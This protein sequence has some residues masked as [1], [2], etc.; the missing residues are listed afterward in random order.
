ME[1]IGAYFDLTTMLSVNMLTSALSLLLFVVMARSQRSG[2]VRNS[3]H[4][5]AE[6]YLLL[7]LGFGILQIPA[8]DFPLPHLV[9]IANLVID[10]GVALG[11]VAAN[12]L[13]D[14]PARS[15]WPL[16]LPVALA[17]AQVWHILFAPLAYDGLLMLLGC[18]SRMSMA[19]AVG[20]VLWR[21]AS[22]VQRPPARLAAVFHGIWAALL[23]LRI[24]V[25]LAG[26]GDQTALEVSSSVG[27]TG[28]FMLTWMI[29]ICLLWILARHLD[30]Q[31]VQQASRDPLTNLL[32]RRA[33]WEAG[34]GRGS[35]PMELIMLDIDHFKSINDRWGHC[36]GDEVL[37]LVARTIA[38]AVR[39]GDM[40]ARV[41][42]EE[43][44]VL[45][46]AGTDTRTNNIAERIRV[47]VAEARLVREDGSILQCTVSIGHARASGGD[48]R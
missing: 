13:L 26:G 37:T 6:S 21:H 46:A 36:V 32:N 15:N 25:L 8:E 3:L 28:R 43:F 34:Q 45:P 11:L 35:R 23:A 40:V 38:A 16:A 20:W 7:T 31:L 27:L 33:I 19:I 1:A 41:G 10:A 17:A 14:R 47:A 4:R 12:Q 2:E 9:A 5:W 48:G 29:A 18:I 22:A 42:G 44:M 24:V 39:E 30:D